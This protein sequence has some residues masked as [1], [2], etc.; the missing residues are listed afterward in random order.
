MATKTKTKSTKEIALRPVLVTTAHRGVFFGYLGSEYKAGDSTAILTNPRN[1]LYWSKQCG[2]FMGL[3]AN[4]PVGDS[5]VGACPSRSEIRNITSVTDV[6]EAAA[7]VWTEK[8]VH[9]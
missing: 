2:G 3:A 5:R 8:P 6:S 1:C 7:K 9:T 4:G